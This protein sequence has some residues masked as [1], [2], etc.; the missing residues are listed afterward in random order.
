MKR[1]KY[2][3]SAVYKDAEKGVVKVVGQIKPWTDSEWE[4]HLKKVNKAINA[5]NAITKVSAFAKV[6]PSDTYDELTGI[7]VASRKSE[8]KAIK[9][10]LKQAGEVTE[11]LLGLVSVIEK[12][13][14]A[15]HERQLKIEKEMQ[16]K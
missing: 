9:A 13:V 7:V 2:V 10:K 16:S 6:A 4:S 15:A 8:L 1:L 3:D 12:D 11:H 5:Y 14:A